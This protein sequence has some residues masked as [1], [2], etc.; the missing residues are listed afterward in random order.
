MEKE[1][2]STCP[3]KKNNV[4]KKWIVGIDEA[5]RGPLAGPVHVGVFATSIDFD[6]RLIEDAR[7]SKQINACER[8]RIF[9]HVKTLQN[10]RYAVA[11]SKN[12]H[13]DAKGIVPAVESAL[14]RALES[15]RISPQ[16]SLIL[17]DGGL[18]APRKYVHQ[19]T[20]VRGD[21]LKKV[22][23]VASIL[24]KVSRDKYM[25]RIATQYPEYGF[26]SHKGYGTQK[27]REAIKTYGLTR[28][29]RTTFC[30][31]IVV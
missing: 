31:N 10:V 19:E 6:E 25:E 18:R 28:L 5:G 30:R 16:E 21:A 26:E 17:L 24:A 2:A 3:M 7:D 1:T 20:Y 29:H 14:K 4:K 27:H 9:E 22:I 8:M 23:S 11:Y 13:I 12:N 15:L